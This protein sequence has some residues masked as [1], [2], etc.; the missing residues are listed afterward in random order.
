[1]ALEITEDTRG[2][3]IASEIDL[4]N[5]VVLN[6]K[7][8]TRLTGSCKSSPDISLASA[9]IAM[10]IDWRTEY[11]L[12]SDHLPIAPSITCDH[13]TTPQSFHQLPQS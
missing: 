2:N 6:E 12:G 11:A 7:A 4:S 9:N 8:S 3:T 13:H 10:K 1:M 5:H